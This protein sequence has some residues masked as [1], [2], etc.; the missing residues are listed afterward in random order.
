MNP[1]VNLLW[2]YCQAVKKFV[3]QPLCCLIEFIEVN[4]KFSLKVK[5]VL[6]KLDKEESFFGEKTLAVLS[7]DFI[8]FNNVIVKSD[9][10]R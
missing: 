1:P 2:S 7:L 5:V 9:C 3:L 4:F 8:I 6:S 10:K